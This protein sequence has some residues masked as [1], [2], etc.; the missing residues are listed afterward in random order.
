MKPESSRRAFLGTTAALGAKR[1]CRADHHC[2]CARCSQTGCGQFG[3]RRLRA[4]GFTAAAGDGR[5]GA[6]FT[7]PRTWARCL[8]S[9]VR[10]TDRGRK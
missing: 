5:F 8:T 6:L 7:T 10:S 2:I 3:P 1:P 9:R 4:A